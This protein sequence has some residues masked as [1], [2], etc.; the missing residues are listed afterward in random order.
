MGVYKYPVHLLLALS[1]KNIFPSENF[2][3]NNSPPSF[4][5]H[6]VLVTCL[7]SLL[8]LQRRGFYEYQFQLKDIL[9]SECRSKVI[10]LT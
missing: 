7:P 4:T 2:S 3:K 1:A 10:L 8:H 6:S 9:A 5:G